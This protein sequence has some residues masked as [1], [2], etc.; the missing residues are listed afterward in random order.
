MMDDR[1]ELERAMRP[2]NTPPSTRTEGPMS[3][4]ILHPAAAG[5]LMALQIAYEEATLQTLAKDTPQ[6]SLPNALLELMRLWAES[7]Y[8]RLYDA[9]GVSEDQRK[10]FD[11]LMN[12]DLPTA[13]MDE[14]QARIRL[15]MADPP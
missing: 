12:P 14:M 6:D 15:L 5:L 9:E 4:P 11:V 10:V 2:C 13:L 8:E 7:G 1:D 3:D